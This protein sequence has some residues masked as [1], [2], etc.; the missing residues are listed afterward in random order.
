[1][2]L[3]NLYY[4]ES[5]PVT[6]YMDSLNFAKDGGRF[7]FQLTEV[8]TDDKYNPNDLG[9]LFNNNFFDHYFY[10]GYNWNKPGSWYNQ[11]HSNNN[12][13]YSR[14]YRPDAY[15][16]FSYNGNINGQLKN[17]MQTGINLNYNHAGNDF[18]EPRVAGR[19]YKSPSGASFGG[20]LNSNQ[21][22]KYY[23]FIGLTFGYNNIFHNNYYLFDIENNYRFNDKFSIGHIINFDPS[24]NQSGF[25][26]ISG[27]DI[28][29]SRRNRTTVENIINSKYY[30]NNRNGI[31]FR[32]RHYWSE[33]NAKE[34]FTL[35][36][37]GSLLKNVN[38]NKN[39]NQNL[40]IFNI[41]MV[42]TWEFAP[43]SFI[44]IVWKNSIYSGD[45]QINDS[46]FKNF[47]N[48]VSAAQNNNISLK[49]IYYLDAVSLRK[50]HH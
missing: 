43:G 19:V 1:M 6:G 24:Y 46:Y 7:N 11:L 16:V 50:K 9:L 42:Y 25:T 32:L 37:D 38:Y 8:L 22:K 13:T 48:T 33:V 18:Y 39:N 41:D 30:F 10:I 4:K 47:R 21:A 45:Q 12:F 14:R 5:K 23:Y 29:F 2:A 36:Q 35:Q 49:V 44:N 27:S 15:Q 17:L 31:T 20:W 40:N 3:S 26:D 28:I 34:F